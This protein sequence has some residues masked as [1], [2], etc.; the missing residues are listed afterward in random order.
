MATI[1]TL[2]YLTAVKRGYVEFSGDYFWY[3]IK[4]DIG[5]IVA[6]LKDRWTLFVHNRVPM[7]SGS[8]MVEF[9]SDTVQPY[10]MMAEDAVRHSFEL[11]DRLSAAEDYINGLESQ[12]NGLIAARQEVEVAI[13]L[14]EQKALEEVAVKEIAAASDVDLYVKAG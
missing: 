7:F 13:A 12:L 9:A 6:P 5:Q 2:D 10:A 4:A 11:M 3:N 8:E 14:H 1:Y